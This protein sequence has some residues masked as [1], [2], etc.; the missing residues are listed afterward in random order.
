[1]FWGLESLGMCSFFPC[2]NM[3]DWLSLQLLFS[4]Q[5]PTTLDVFFPAWQNMANIADDAFS[6]QNP[7]NNSPK[8]GPAWFVCDCF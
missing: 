5:V 3:L 2:V 8:K 6:I 4:K 1:M 7:P